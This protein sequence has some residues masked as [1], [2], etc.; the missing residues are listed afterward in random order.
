MVFL[1]FW[2]SKK[3]WDYLNNQKEPQLQISFYQKLNEYLLGTTSG[4]QSQTMM[5][6]WG[7]ETFIQPKPIRPY[8]VQLYMWF[9]VTPHNPSPT[10][11]YAT[12]P[13]M[14]MQ[15]YV[16][17][18]HA[19]ILCY[20]TL[21][22]SMTLCTLLTFLIG[23]GS[24]PQLIRP[25]SL[26]L[27]DSMQPCCKTLCTFL[28]FLIGW[29]S[30]PQPIRHYPMRSYATVHDPMWWYATLHDTTPHHSHSDLTLHDSTWS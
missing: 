19:P 6:L 28:T 16:T 30:P 23:W 9:Y 5:E 18:L 24:P 21:H 22:N 12:P 7:S 29:G 17:T 20:M 25:Y 26:T 10:Q 27:H 3:N 2:S 1:Y 4:N 14:T 8:S 15:P 13:Y 11:C